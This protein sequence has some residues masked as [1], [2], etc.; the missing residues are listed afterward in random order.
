MNEQKNGTGLQDF[1]KKFNSR[2][3]HPIF[4]FIKYGLSGGAATT[5]HMTL[6]FLL[7]LTL[8][9]AL[10]GEDPFVKVF[11]L[12]GVD[13]AVHD[14]SDAVRST[15]SMYANAVAFVFSNMVAYLINVLWVFKRGR[16]H[17]AVELLLFYAVSSISFF[18]GTALQGG[19]VRWTGMETS[20]AF[21]ACLVTSTLI[22]Y[23][24]RK[25]LIFKG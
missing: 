22:N 5:V 7:T 12:F 8:F 23:V 21:V 13:F 17:W 19:L 2:D 18:P 11:G 25:F 24:C 14:I 9:P 20:Y 10:T 1:I 16:H 6:F 3:A 15:R 4:Q